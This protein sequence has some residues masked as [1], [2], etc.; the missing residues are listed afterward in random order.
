MTIQLK[1][2]NPRTEKISEFFFPATES[3]L[4]LD[5]LNDAIDCACTILEWRLIPNH[6]I[7][8]V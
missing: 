7:Q 3:A 1:Y 8:I 6:R 5:Y 2:F 4:A